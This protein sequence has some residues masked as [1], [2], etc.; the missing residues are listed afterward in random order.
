[1]TII[2]IADYKND[3]YEGIKGVVLTLR[4][5]QE[6]L[7][8]TVYIFNISK[9]QSIS[10]YEI[11]VS[12]LDTFK[13]KIYFLKPEIVIFHSVY[14]LIYIAFYRFLNKERIPYLVEPHGGTTI[15][16]M[17]KSY[18]KKKL[19]NILM[20]N[21][22]FVNAK[23]IV[24]LNKYECEKCVFK[25]IRKKSLIIP[26]GIYLP[27]FKL[28]SSEKPMDKINFTFLARIDIYH[29]GID[30]LLDA[31]SILSKTNDI[32]K[33]TFNFYG[34]SSSKNDIL[35]LTNRLTSIAP[36]LFSH[37][38]VLGDQK[39]SAF[40]NTNIYV[41]TSRYEGMP[42]SVLE[43]LS[44]GNPCIITPQ[45]NMQD[46]ITENSCGWIT[47]LDSKSIAD[48][49]FVAI[50]DYSEKRNE[51][52]NNSIKSVQSFTWDLIAKLAVCEYSK[53]IACSQ[54]TS[55]DL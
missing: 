20:F 15:E 32:D 1:M 45:T 12:D 19:A 44:Y 43:A 39:V 27:R 16:N 51:Y 47:L 11:S 6:K 25:T 8:N 26:N 52:I 41:L 23:A 24:Y 35:Y 54:K 30:L 42:L 40:I 10:D 14:K 18:F 13:N 53:T 5:E 2:H 3:K 17:K 22:F 55:C 28:S 46:I 48:T 7:G 4:T 33:I 38:Q 50:K 31:I 49:L 36:N 34:S 29:K 9:N 37:G 21:N